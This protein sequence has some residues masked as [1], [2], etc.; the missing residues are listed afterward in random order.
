[1]R[2]E[3]YGGSITI[4]LWLFF[5]SQYR[6]N[7][8]GTLRCFGKILVSKNFMDKRGGGEGVSQISV[9]NLL[10]HTTSKLCRWTLLCFKK[11]QV[12]KNLRKMRGGVCHN[13]PSLFFVS[14]PNNF[15]ERPFCV[16]E[17][18]GYRKSYAYKEGGITILRQKKICL[19]LPKI[20]VGWDLCF[21]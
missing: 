7:S 11:I 4:F 14:V 16:W 8:K 3:G 5:V 12:R 2:G 18:F 9:K 1:M 15:V 6:K 19:T 20:F 21:W 10:F 13:F 17:S